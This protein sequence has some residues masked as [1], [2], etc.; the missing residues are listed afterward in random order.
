MNKEIL[1]ILLADHDQKCHHL[2]SQA[3]HETRIPN[4]FHSVDHGFQLMEYLYHPGNVVPD[5]LFMDHALPVKNGIHC[6]T[7]LRRN[8]NFRNL[9]IA[10]YSSTGSDKQ[11]EEVLIKGANIFFKKPTSLPVLQVILD[12]ICNLKWQYDTSGLRKENFLLS[13]NRIKIPQES[14]EEIK[15]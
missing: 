1:N 7:E 5:I 9:T 12:H 15:S 8:K 6:L 13:L 2:F 10:I 14:L 4:S 3:L 11:K